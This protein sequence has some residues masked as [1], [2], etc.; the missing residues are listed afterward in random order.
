MPLKINA[1]AFHL[2]FKNAN[3]CLFISESVC[4]IDLTNYKTTALNNK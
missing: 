3:E 4:S 2:L 1:M